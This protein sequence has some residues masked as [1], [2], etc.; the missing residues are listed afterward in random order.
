M[1]NRPDSNPGPLAG[2]PLTAPPSKTSRMLRASP[3]TLLALGFLGLIIIGALLLW[4]PQSARTGNIDL[5][6]A[7]FMAT[8][9]VTVTGLA[10]IH[11]AQSLSGFGQTVLVILVQLG[12][13]GFVTF[14]VLTALALG[15]KLSIRQQALALQAFNQTSVARI[16]HT[17]INVIKLALVIELIA[18]IILS[19]W[20]WRDMPASDA[21]INGVYHSIMGFNNAGFSLLDHGLFPYASDPVVIAVISSLIILGGI[22]FS[23]LGDISHKQRWSTLMPY[24]KAMILGSIALNLVGFCF[25]LGLEYN[26]PGT[27]GPL[28]WDGKLLS[29]WMHSVTARTAGFTTVDVTL[30]QDSTTLLLFVLMFIGGGSLSTAS[31]IKVGTFL[32][33]LAAMWSYIVQRHDVILLRRSIAPDIIQKSLALLLATLLFAIAGIFLLTLLDDQP[34]IDLLFEGISAL[35]TTGLTRNLTTELNQPA[36]LVLAVMMF[37]GRLGPLTL[38]Y[39]LAT[40]K[41]RR[42]RYPVAEFPVG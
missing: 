8:S 17:A 9:A 27:L 38:V 6:D 33:L 28:G 1:A 32:V 35:S 19:L 36:Q 34:F 31:G 30:M 11:P 41:T 5:F 37:V 4:L 12:G 40:R 23:V 2:E 14:A 42:V 13:L 24:T 15:R 20:W 39:S 25:I 7:F 10:V 16:K 21:V 26:N 22:G 18:A 29:G 3:P